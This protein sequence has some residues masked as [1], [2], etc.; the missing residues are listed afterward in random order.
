MLDGSIRRVA[1]SH[2]SIEGDAEAR[3]P[4]PEHAQAVLNG[5]NDDVVVGGQ[6]HAVVDG[7]GHAPR[8]VRPSVNEHLRVSTE[9]MQ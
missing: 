2:G 8:G 5:N 4:L 6:V 9:R 7:D 3:R 1:V